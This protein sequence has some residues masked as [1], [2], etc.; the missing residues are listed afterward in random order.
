M[1][2]L[3]KAR[4][5]VGILTEMGPVQG[6]THPPELTVNTLAGVH[7]QYL[8]VKGCEAESWG[9]RRSVFWVWRTVNSGGE[10]G[11]VHLK[12]PRIRGS[13]IAQRGWFLLVLALLGIGGESQILGTDADRRGI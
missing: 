5:A 12:S 1:L 4:F 2:W 10:M 8:G 11:T 13:Y 6:G 3:C 7:N 9:D